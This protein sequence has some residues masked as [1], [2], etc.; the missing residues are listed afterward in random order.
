MTCYFCSLQVTFSLK[1][2]L[3]ILPAS[4]EKLPLHMSSCPPGVYKP[5]SNWNA[6]QQQGDSLLSVQGYTSLFQETDGVSSHWNSK[7]VN[8]AYLVPSGFWAAFKVGFTTSDVS[9]CVI[10]YFI[11]LLQRL[12]VFVGKGMHVRTRMKQRKDCGDKPVVQIFKIKY[13]D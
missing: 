3:L 11:V 1:N 2:M 13:A 7:S 12:G 10:D 8:K 6:V 5:M 9:E 4:P